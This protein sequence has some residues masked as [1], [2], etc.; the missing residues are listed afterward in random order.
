M[1][2]KNTFSHILITRFN[3]PWVNGKSP[4]DIWL[5]NRM[6][7]FFQYCLPSVYQQTNTNYNWIIYLDTQTPNWALQKLKSKI[8]SNTYLIKVSTFDV[9]KQQVSNDVLSLCDNNSKF[10]ITSRLDNDD[11]ISPFFIDLIQQNYNPIHNSFINF[12]GGICY[13]LQKHLFSKY[14]YIN[15]PFVSKIENIENKITTIIEH[16]HTSLNANFQIHGNHWVQFVHNNNISNSIEGKIL[17]NRKILN[18]NKWIANFNLKLNTINAIWFKFQQ[19]KN[20]IIFLTKRIINKIIH[21]V[22]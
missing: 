16:D 21:L 20:K 11:I 1:E 4:D 12:D 14:K 18:A 22:K 6:D 8:R 5:K 10:V 3:V 15:G 7:L 13:H 2:E 17:I 9:M 19:S